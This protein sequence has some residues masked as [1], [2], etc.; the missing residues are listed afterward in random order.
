MLQ[1]FGRSLG[2]AM[3]DAHRGSSASR[4][5]RGSA[6]RGWDSLVAI[7]AVA[8]ACIALAGCGSSATSSSPLAARQALPARCSPKAV[9][10]VPA[11]RWSAAREELAP[12]GATA[13]RLCRYSSLNA[14]PRLTLVSSRLLKSPAVVREL[15][16][17]FDRLPPTPPGAVACP[18][19]DGSQIVALL[20]YPGDRTVTITVGLTGCVAVTNGSVQRTAAGIGSP[21]AFGPQLVAQLE[22]LVGGR[23]AVTG[24]F[25]NAPYSQP[26]N[27]R[28]GANSCPLAPPNPYLPRRAGCVTVRPA[29]VDGDGRPDLILLYG[30]LSTH[31]LGSG[32]IPTAFTLKVLRASG[33]TLVAHIPHPQANPTIVRLRNVNERPG[34]EIFIH[35]TH[36]S[37]GELMGV[38]TFDG[39]SLHRAGGFWYGGDSALVQGFTCHR[40]P[41]AT[42]VQHQFLLE[43]PSRTG[44]WRRTDTTYVW[45]GARLRR[46]A[47][48]TTDRTGIP[49]ASLASPNC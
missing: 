28:K 2:D 25:P 9:L 10:S 36:I 24:R 48:R 23:A 18:N 44:R 39:H 19:D 4:S 41:P 42:I 31:R 14:R 1:L 13:I 47:T 38:Y 32:F 8:T 5:L 16:G 45:V 21:P 6:A 15:V 11:E 34:V 17:E 27:W 30:Q 43:G 22:R 29:D 12:A 35:E 26:G 33:G 3:D 37:S 7:A 40:G 46:G 49:P 20:A